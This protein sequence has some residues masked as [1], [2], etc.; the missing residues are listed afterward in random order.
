MLPQPL[1]LGEC[2]DKGKSSFEKSFLIHLGQ[3]N[4]TR[5]K[6]KLHAAAWLS[7]DRG[8]YIL[9][10]SMI[11]ALIPRLSH[12][13]LNPIQFDFSADA[14]PDRKNRIVNWNQDITSTRIQ[15]MHSPDANRNACHHHGQPLNIA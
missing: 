13:P 2:K 15:I 14:G 3:E 11:R 6:A 4:S 9:K 12:Q 10:D 7:S 1:F 8:G 5:K